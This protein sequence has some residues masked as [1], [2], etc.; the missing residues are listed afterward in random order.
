MAARS[1]ITSVVAPPLLSA[2]VNASS[3]AMLLSGASRAPTWAGAPVKREVLR[4][5]AMALSA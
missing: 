3:P 4:A 2:I 5:R 1:I